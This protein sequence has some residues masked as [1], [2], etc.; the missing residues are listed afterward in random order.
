[1]SIFLINYI[2]NNKK[3]IV[4]QIVSHI[5]KEISYGH[6]SEIWY[7]VAVSRQCCY[8][9]PV[10]LRNVAKSFVVKQRKI[11]RKRVMHSRHFD[12]FFVLFI[13]VLLVAKFI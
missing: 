5:K 3:K 10:L 1:M 4:L 2:N 9:P 8:V 12:L 7:S 6:S 13:S 11:E